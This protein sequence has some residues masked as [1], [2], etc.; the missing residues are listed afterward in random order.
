MVKL[1]LGSLA[2]SLSVGS[3]KSYLAEF[4]ATL[5]FVFTG[6]GLAISYCKLTRDA[7]PD[8]T[9]LVALAIA[10]ALAL[11]IGATVAA[12]VSRGNLN[13][14]V[15][16]G[17][18]IGDNIIIITGV[19][20]WIAQCLG[21]IVACFLVQFVTPSMTAPTHGVAYDISGLQE[22]VMETIITFVLVYM[23]YVTTDNP[24]NGLVGTIGPITIG[25]IVGANIFVGGVLTRIIITLTM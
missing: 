13:P 11:L 4:I 5:I 8:T 20:Y 2:D 3:F 15:T 6:V 7:T 24:K 21:F 12:N 25:L 18:A 23:A 17:L 16:F 10:H 14:A 1:A 19:C 22:G 9:R